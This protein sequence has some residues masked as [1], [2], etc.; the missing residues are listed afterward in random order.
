MHPHEYT[1]DF[2]VIHFALRARRSSTVPGSLVH[3]RS[4]RRTSHLYERQFNPWSS[5]GHWRLLT[6]LH[7]SLEAQGHGWRLSALRAFEILTSLE[8][9][10]SRLAFMVTSSNLAITSSLCPT[11]PNTGAIYLAHLTVLRYRISWTR[12]NEGL[13]RYHLPYYLSTMYIHTNS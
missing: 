13:G 12:K 2:S 9:Y 11:K 7:H 8:H 10:P 1:R 3:E 4:E 5:I 6:I